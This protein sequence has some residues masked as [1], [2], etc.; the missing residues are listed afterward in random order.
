MVR[1]GDGREGTAVKILAAHDGGSGCTWYRMYVPLQ[2]AAK[3]GKNIDVTFYSASPNAM[4]YSGDPALTEPG[5]ADG[6]DIFIAQRVNYY[7]GLGVWRRMYT[8]ERR[9]VYENDDDIWHVTRENP[10]FET[11]K[12]GT[13]VREAVKR[14]C[15]TACLIT[16]TT[17]QLGDLHREMSPGV[18]VEVLPNYV[19]EWVLDLEHDDREGHLRV[20]WVGGSSHLRDLQVPGS[21]LA[22]FLKRF[23]DWHAYINGVDFR[24]KMK[25]QKYE[26]GGRAYHVPWVPVV[27]RPKLYYRSIDFDIGIAPL[28]D[29]QFARAKSPVKLLEYM[30]RGVVPVASDVEPYRN[31]ITHGE[32]GFLVKQGRDHE[33]LG[34]LS[35][36][37]RDENLRLKMSAAATARARENTIEKHWRKWINCYS[38]LFP[39]GWEFQDGGKN[40]LQDVAR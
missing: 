19:P 24:D 2:A 20:G 30:A 37:A 18:P 34:H 23:P 32:N 6:H 40:E 3:Y 12:E 36:L 15:D 7:D 11:Y 22:R 1:Q 28:L 39:V 25:L 14:Y 16:C 13:E 26:D 17:P 21:S 4:D 31:F 10:G 5:Q 29:T 8:P 38:M 35:E 9:T 27:A 33:W